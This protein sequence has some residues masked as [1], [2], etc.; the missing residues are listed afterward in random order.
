V[1]LEGSPRTVVMAGP[2]DDTGFVR[3]TSNMFREE[4]RSWVPM[5]PEMKNFPRYDGW[6]PTRA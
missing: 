2:L 6:L 5:S 1:G 3:P 4:A